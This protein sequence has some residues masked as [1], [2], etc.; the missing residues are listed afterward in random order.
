MHKTRELTRAW[1]GVKPPP[2]RATLVAQ[3]EN[4]EPISWQKVANLYEYPF[5]K[6]H[7][8]QFHRVETGGTLASAN[9][10]Y[11]DGHNRQERLTLLLHHTLWWSRWDIQMLLDAFRPKKLLLQCTNLSALASR[12]GCSAA[13]WQF[14]PGLAR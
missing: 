3:E 13:R 1:G 9:S 2:T 4:P 8:C 6:A 14:R 12:L 5:V 7:F 10:E 11:N